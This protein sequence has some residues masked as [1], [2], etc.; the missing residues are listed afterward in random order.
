MVVL[1]I[2]FPLKNLA[3]FPPNVLYSTSFLIKSIN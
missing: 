2:F 3:L 1:G